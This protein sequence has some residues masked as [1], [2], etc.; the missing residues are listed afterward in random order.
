[1]HTRRQFYLAHFY[2]QC[3]GEIK[4]F[5][6]TVP[7]TTK[8]HIQAKLAEWTAHVSKLRDSHECLNFF[9]TDQLVKLSRAMA[10]VVHKD[11]SLSFE[12]SMLLRLI[13]RGIENNMLRPMLLKLKVCY[14]WVSANVRLMEIWFSPSSDVTRVLKNGALQLKIFERPPDVT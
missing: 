3:L 14:S 13:A 2:K 7:I 6:N 12:A 1:M 9:T 4:L 5:P 8:L 10:R 11:K